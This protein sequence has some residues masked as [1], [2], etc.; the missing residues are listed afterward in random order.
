MKRN[1]PLFVAAD[2]LSRLPRIS[3]FVCAVDVERGGEGG[4]EGDR[5]GEREGEAE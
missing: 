2:Y 3:A 4:K 5:E 1:M